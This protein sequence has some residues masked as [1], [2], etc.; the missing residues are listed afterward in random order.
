MGLYNLLGISLLWFVSL[1]Y[2][3]HISRGLFRE[4]D[5]GTQYIAKIHNR[6]QSPVVPVT[7]VGD[8]PN[9]ESR[10]VSQSVKYSKKLLW[11]FIPI[12]TVLWCCRWWLPSTP[13]RGHRH[14]SSTYFVNRRITI[15]ES[16]KETNK[17]TNVWLDVLRNKQS[18][19]QTTKQN[20]HKQMVIVTSHYLSSIIYIFLRTPHVC[21]NFTLGYPT[22]FKTSCVLTSYYC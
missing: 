10:S 20:K 17:P 5:Y 11:V 8:G 13:S 2:K 9:H 22:C 4:L 14:I 16:N 12:S 3:M 1:T 19:N 21:N 15:N 7:A 18:I 6:R